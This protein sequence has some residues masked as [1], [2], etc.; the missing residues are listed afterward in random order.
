MT[1]ING[2][3][4]YTAQIALQQQ[5]QGQRRPQEQED[6][7]Q[8]LNNTQKTSA[9]SKREE[10]FRAILENNGDR[11]AGN[12]GFQASSGGEAV[13]PDP[14]QGRGSILDVSA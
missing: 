8:Q 12:G 9:I 1:L 5:T 6:Q 4:S 11:T 14:T 13:K 7:Q 3:N 10:L 2:F